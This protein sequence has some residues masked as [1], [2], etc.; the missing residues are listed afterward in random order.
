M[1]MHLMFITMIISLIISITWLFKWDR[2]N[3]PLITNGSTLLAIINLFSRK[4]Q[5][6]LLLILF[7]LITVIVI[8]FY[9]TYILYG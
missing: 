2:I 1:G 3:E 5:K 8:I 7:G 9:V 6:I 4:T